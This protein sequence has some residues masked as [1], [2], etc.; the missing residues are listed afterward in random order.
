MRSHLLSAATAAMLLSMLAGCGAAAAPK[1][2]GYAPS[3]PAEAYQG[4]APMG[5]SDEAPP[6]SAAAASDAPSMNAGG[7]APR[8]AAAPA[9]YHPPTAAGAVAT[10]TPA[11]T[12]GKV[13]T[14]TA[15]DAN[16]KEATNPAVLIMY[17]GAVSMTVDEDRVSGAIDKIADV[18][19]GFG[20]HLA[21]RT[22]N[23][24]TIKV[25]SARFRDTLSEIEKVGMITHRSV[26][27]DDVSE[28]YHDA[29]VRITN[30]KATRNRLQEFLSKAA[31]IND[32]LTVEQQL[33]RIAMDI[34]RLE[35]RMRFLRERT[36]LSSI[37][38][39][40]AAKP[41][42]KAILAKDPPPPPPPPPPPGAIDLPV[43]WL[44]ELGLER[45]TQ[46]KK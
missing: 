23:T 17:T 1:S 20:G 6:P 12:A 10:T 19:D 41:K 28:E 5:D 9:A 39:T 33:E 13:T 15:K 37:T 32:M 22:D 43:K 14:T 21:G 26:V 24:V 16:G 46:L 18:A 27:A 11:T 8:P 30:L 4:G 29:E 44:D 25:P 7:A 2:A 36:A 31:N 42:D 35:G 45:L 40:I 38:V 34:D 3:Q